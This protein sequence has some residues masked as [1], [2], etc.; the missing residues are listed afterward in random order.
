MN[1]L[2]SKVK[3]LFEQVLRGEKRVPKLDIEKKY[4]EISDRFATI[5]SMKFSDD[6]SITWGG[7]LKAKV[8]DKVVCL[9]KEEYEEYMKPRTEIEIDETT[10]E[11]EIFTKER[12]KPS[13]ENVELNRLFRE[14]WE[15][16]KNVEND[17]WLIDKIFGELE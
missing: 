8:E 16:S 7:W 13:E 12:P 1:Y 10:G 14:V 5:Y 11:L 6:L 17:R 4:L 2:E 9:F 15:Y 3:E